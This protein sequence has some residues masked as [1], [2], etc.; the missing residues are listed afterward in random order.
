M[1]FL[2]FTC[3]KNRQTKPPPNNTNMT[4]RNPS[5][6]LCRESHSRKAT[7]GFSLSPKK[8]TAGMTLVEILLVLGLLVVIGGAILVGV[9]AV[10]DGANKSLCISQMQEVQDK[11]R[12]YAALNNL[13][14]GDDL[15]QADLIGDGR[16]IQRIPICKGRGTYAYTAK[17]PA[18]GVSCITCSLNASAGHAVPTPN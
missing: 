10:R 2:A 16:M 18:A 3:P 5:N 17:I 13:N 14:P 4:D 15:I 8:S 7:R 1:L 12:A 11:M 6:L 9:Q